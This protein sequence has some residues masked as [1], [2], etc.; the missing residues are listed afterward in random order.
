MNT[1]NQTQSLCAQCL[2]KIPADIVEKDGRIFMQKDCPDHGHQ[3]T[4]I[5]SD[6]LWYHRMMGF[7]AHLTAPAYAKST[8]QNSCPFDCGYCPSHS[9]RM[10]L[11]VVPITSA[12]N[13]NCPVCYTLNKNQDPYFMSKDEF[14]AILEQIRAGDP[15]MQII[16]FTGGEPLMHPAFCEMV[17]MCKE[18]GIQR[19]TVSTNGLKF[20]ED[21]SLLPRLTEMD[22]RIVLSFNSFHPEP[23]EIT[24]GRNLLDQKLDILKLLEQYKPAT[25][26]LSVAAAGVNDREIGHIVRYVLDTPHI[27]SAEIHTVTFTG[28]N[29]G[30]F[31]TG[32]RLTTPDVIA[33]IASENKEILSDD[34]LPSPAAHPLCYAVCY[35][36]MLEDGKRIPFTRFIPETDILKMLAG[37]LYMEPNM[38][39]EEV[40][41]D[42]MNNVWSREQETDADAAILSALKDLL[43]RMFPSGNLDL[44]A[45]RRIAERASKA[46]Y[47]HSH[48][49]AGNFD[50]QRITQC[51]GAVPDGQG[52]S[53]PT[54]AYNILYRAKDS[55]F[56]RFHKGA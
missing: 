10:Y 21:D 36:L 23:Y 38:I 45:R 22:A 51:C 30:R 44:A 18:A 9:Q 19:I 55:R 17:E 11:P 52:G 40:L 33:A 35:L 27:V 53:I 32:T 29:I 49:D 31:D 43:K 37:N 34:F 46:V 6:A 28:Q 50:A 7:S 16:N 2:T 42:A 25:T 26:L 13:L 56:H 47:I 3:E 1:I 4:L 14:A 5:S 41:T 20:L 8:T 24:S 39:T 48:M 54:C 12:C 15:D